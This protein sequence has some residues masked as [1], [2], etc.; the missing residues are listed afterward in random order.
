M[1][2]KYC[3]GRCR[4]RLPCKQQDGKSLNKV[5]VCSRWELCPAHVRKHAV[6]ALASS[7]PLPSEQ[8]NYQWKNWKELV[9]HRPCSQVLRPQHGSGGSHS[10]WKDGHLPQSSGMPRMVVSSRPYKPP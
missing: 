10:S 3:Q 5:L 7:S 2:R 4:R 9:S 6:N 8:V 1:S